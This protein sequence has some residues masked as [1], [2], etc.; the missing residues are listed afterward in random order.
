[1][2]DIKKIEIKTI[3]KYRTRKERLE[4]EKKRKLMDNSPLLLIIYI[5]G[6]IGIVWA[7]SE[8]INV[9]EGADIMIMGVASVETALLWYLYFYRQRGFVIASVI[10]ISAAS[11]II[12]PQIYSMSKYIWYIEARLASITDFIGMEVAIAILMLLIY[13]IFALEFVLRNHSIMF[14]M[15]IAILLTVPS[16]GHE[17]GFVPLIMIIIFET[18]FFVLNMTDKRKLKYT[19]IMPKRAR[20]GMLSTLITIGILVCAFVPDWSGTCPFPALFVFADPAVLSGAAPVRSPETCVILVLVCRTSVCSVCL[21]MIVSASLNFASIRLTSLPRRT[22]SRALSPMDATRPHSVVHIAVPR[23]EII[24][25]IS[26]VPLLTMS[27]ATVP[28][29]PS[30]GRSEVS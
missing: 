28:R 1:M 12:M 26:V 10:L 24:W 30:R 6:M 19:L 13:L 15:G 7:L 25:L 2:R 4:E 29:I 16:S 3:K 17:V 27:P 5:V 14:L 9:F 18:G 21:V 8:L 20:A 23:P 22:A 11:V